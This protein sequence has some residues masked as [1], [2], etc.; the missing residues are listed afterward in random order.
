[1]TDMKLI[2]QRPPDLLEFKHKQQDCPLLAAEGERQ[3][4]RERGARPPVEE[5]RPLG[6]AGDGAPAEPGVSQE[7][8][9]DS[10]VQQFIVEPKGGDSVNNNIGSIFILHPSTV[11]LGSG[12]GGIKRTGG[13]EGDPPISTPQQESQ[14]QS[15]S[16]PEEACRASV[17]VQ[18]EGGK[19][20][21]YPIPASGK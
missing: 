15:Q 16:Q 9:S 18:E 21:H 19:E 6:R 8:C 5:V 2:P 13:G 1:M 11:I 17:C 3:E 10:R 12:R 20:L 14:S 4:S 7:P